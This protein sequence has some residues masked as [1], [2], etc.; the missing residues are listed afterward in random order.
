VT[1]VGSTLVWVI[2]NTVEFYPDSLLSRPFF[3]GC[4]YF[5]GELVSCNLVC[6]KHF[7]VNNWN[8][9]SFKRPWGAP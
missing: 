6:R 1:F 3:G 7:N 8:K 9:Q 4:G 2:E 5:A